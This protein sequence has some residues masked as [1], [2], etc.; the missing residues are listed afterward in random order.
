MH[1]TLNAARVPN[2]SVYGWTQGFENSTYLG[3]QVYSW[4]YLTKLHCFRQ[5]WVSGNFDDEISFQSSIKYGYF[6]TPDIHTYIHA[7]MHAYIH[8]Y[9]YIHIH[10]YIHT[11]MHAYIHTYRHTYIHTYTQTYIHTY[12]HTCMHAYIHT[13][14]DSNQATEMSPRIWQT[15]F[16]VD[17]SASWNTYIWKVKHTFASTLADI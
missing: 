2:L 16:G 1:A 10:T 12:I 6:H 17:L 13:Y 4:G 9:T 7:C 5:Q 15:S 3:L 8:T 11:C 14:I